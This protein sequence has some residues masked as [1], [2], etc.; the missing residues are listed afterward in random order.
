MMMP[1]RRRLLEA[2]V[3]ATLIS[4]FAAACSSSSSTSGAA[5]SSASNTNVT[6]GQTIT[7]GIVTPLT[8]PVSSSFVQETIDGAEARIA[9]ASADHE[10]P[11]GE[12]VKLVSV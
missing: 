2:A 7:L 8:G 10:L 11:N 6:A 4:G 3:V 12:T 9:L 1:T 5:G